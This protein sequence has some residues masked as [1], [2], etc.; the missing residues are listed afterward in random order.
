MRGTKIW[1]KVRE[2]KKDAMKVMTN[3][4]SERRGDSAV[5]GKEVRGDSEGR[6]SYP[7]RWRQTRAV[8][9]VCVR[10]GGRHGLGVYFQ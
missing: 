10:T 8:A 6:R 9:C 2:R 1:K 5:R 7:P 4:D 3:E